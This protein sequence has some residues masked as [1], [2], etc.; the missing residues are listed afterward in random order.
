MEWI[1]LDNIMLGEIREP[2]EAESREA[3][4]RDWEVG[5]EN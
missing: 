2:W 3:V 1:G 4:T 5:G